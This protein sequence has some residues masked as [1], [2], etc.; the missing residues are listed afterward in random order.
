MP[1]LAQRKTEVFFRELEKRLDGLGN[2][3]SKVGWLSDGL[4]Y[5]DGTPTAYVAAIQEYGSPANS[6]P[7]RPFMRPT[8]TEQETKWADIAAKG[9][10]RVI[11]GKS[12]GF[13]VLDTI[14]QVAEA[15]VVDKIESI[16]QPPLS[17]ITLGARKYR[18]EG[19]KVTGATI[20]EIAGLLKEGKL[21]ISGVST[22]PLDETHHLIN[23]ITHVTETI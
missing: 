8:A 4:T 2:I 15:D 23:A 22:K 21:D 16:T 1:D 6:I 17:P 12:T 20:G 3:E 14:A 10:V 13:K 11:E 7:A 5:P 18:K 9:A 19:K